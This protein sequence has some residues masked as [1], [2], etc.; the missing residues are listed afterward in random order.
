MVPPSDTPF[1]VE[2]PPS[3]RRG[4][5]A[6]PLH[7]IVAAFAGLMALQAMG[8]LIFGTGQIG[9]TIS[10]FIVVLHNLLALACAWIAFR[11][12][13]GAAALFWFLFAV[14]QV[15]LLVP[16]A[17]LL[18]STLLAQSIVSDA[19]WR[20]L[21][22]LYGAPILMM[23][24][25]P[26]ADRAAR[27]KS[28]VFLD[29]FQV[30]VVVILAFTTFFY[31]PVQQMLPA[32]ALLRNL[33]VSNLQS[34]FLLIAVLVRL[35]FARL[36]AAHGL[37][38]RL[39][40][41]LFTCAVVTF[42]G[43][44]IDQ[45]GYYSLSAWWDLGWAL[46]YVAAALVAFTWTP[47][48]APHPGFESI[49]FSSFLGK[50]LVLVAILF[51]IDMM[52]DKWKA[53]HGAFLTNLAVSASL[54]A[55]TVRL[56]L[57]QFHQQQEIAERKAAQEGLSAANETIANLLDDARVDAAAI[58]LVNQLAGLLQACSSRDEAFRL[59]P[60]RMARLFPGTSGTLTV[61]N[62]SRTR[63][64]G[65]A[66]W[67]AH[68]PPHP[69][70]GHDASAS[71]VHDL[72]GETPASSGPSQPERATVSVPLTA[73]AETVGL[74]I[75]QEDPLPA[76]ALLPSQATEFSR[77]TQMAYAVAEQISLTIANLDL[78]E[79]LR[80]QATR[81]PLTG[82]YNRRYLQ[83]SLEREGHRARRHR[84]S[85][86]LLMVDIDHFKRY[87]DAFGHAAGDEALRLVAK[88]LRRMVRAEDLPCRY[89]GEEFVVL[90]P[91]CPLQNAALR[92]EEIRQGLKD[93]H[94]EHADELPCLVTVSIGVAVFE[95]TTDQ[96][97]L[98]L[99]CAD[100]A[101]YQAKRGGRDRVVVAQPIT[102]MSVDSVP[103]L[104]T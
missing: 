42:V 9:R 23:L 100:E 7:V 85:L 71:R 49:G 88:T 79:A 35:Q 41:F 94:A 13:Q 1:P 82:L 48:A 73:N 103:H 14:T 33:N 76:D 17:M 86:A 24:F 45:H 31:L 53:A 78:R 69:L 8:Y 99:K 66:E 4:G 104:R 65:V 32:D 87:N 72:T 61:F 20:V 57:T 58:A 40:L 74:L 18:S 84:R 95:E 22:C 28:E 44:W 51:S 36:P 91:D 64:E 70:A 92:A 68:P 3:R 52:M 62:A 97:E 98:L 50:N 47:S 43:N 67:G 90:L 101:L 77:H 55:F 25:L 63:A 96:L 10:E 29:L 12:A 75:V 30:G 11:R 59:I 83:E 34:L 38:L 54:L 21:Y 27:L 81:D 102:P 2:T 5:F 56:A 16:A 93:L 6:S 15:I 80:V 26:A 19:T 39:G 60:E 89:G 46:P 37:F